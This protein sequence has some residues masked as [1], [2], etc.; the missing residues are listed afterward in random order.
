MASFRKI[1]LEISKSNGYGQYVISAKYRGKYI[2]THSTDSE[3]YDWLND[4]SNK[5][6][7]SQAKR[8]CYY[9]IIAKYNH[10]FKY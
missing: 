8:A 3:A 9:A 10:L 4:N 6:K 7:H 5:L 1:K 2:S